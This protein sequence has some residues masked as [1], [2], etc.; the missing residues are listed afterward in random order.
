MPKIVRISD[1]K[2]LVPTREFRHARFFFESFNPIQS[3]VYKVYD[4][5]SNLCVAAST[6]A[7][8]TGVAEMLLSHEIRVRGGKGMYVA[9][10]KA[11][12][13]EKIDDWTDPKHHFSD[14]KISICTGDYYLTAARQR[15]LSRADLILITS[16]MLSS[17]CRNRTSEKSDFLQRVGCAVYDESHLLTVP[18]RGDH[19]EVALMNMTEI[20][21]GARLCFLSATMPNVDEVSGWLSR[22]NGMDT[23]LMVSDYRPTKLNVHYERYSDDSRNYD[24]TEAQKVAAAMAIVD[25]FKEDKF[26]VFAHTKRTGELMKIALHR[27]GE[28]ADFYNA[29]L[30]K[31][32]RIRLSSEFNTPVSSGGKRVIVAT[33]GLAWG[34]NL[35]ARRVIVLGV[36]R[37]MS[38]VAGY[39]IQQMVGR[40]GRPKYDP[41]GDAYVLLPGSRFDQHKGRLQA[42][43]RIESQL[44]TFVGG[45][46]PDGKRQDETR[47]NYKALAFHV[48]SEIHHNAIKTTKDV[49]RWYERSLAHHQNQWFDS[50]IVDNVLRLLANCG[51]IRE[52]GGEYKV[53]SS[54]AIASM[55]YYS[56]FDVADYRKSFGRVFGEGQ[57]GDDVAVAVA[58]GNTDTHRG[59]IVSRAEREEMSRF[60]AR[61]QE[62]NGQNEIPGPAV[63]AA[64]CYWNL[65]NGRANPAFNA[66]MRGLQFDFPRVCQV[67]QAVDE[68]ASKWDRFDWFR[69]L[70]L[71]VQYGV[72][73]DLVELCQLPHVGAVRA[74]RL[75]SGNIKTLSQVA[76]NPAKV[77][78]I[79]KLCQDKVD[80][81]VAE[82]RRIKI[83]E[84]CEQ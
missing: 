48:V 58:L 73:G 63:K 54:G 80:E 70:K 76:A 66:M 13:Q 75:V 52:E 23:H 38:E 8:K 46:S 16:E 56:P 39:D 29:D 21:R 78:N 18:G 43:E 51:A 74:Q 44:L 26:L 33:S 25:Y 41:A 72:K 36:H 7:G 14:L 71:R 40:S 64:F 24:D 49:H 68:M 69:Q 79:T 67:L 6:A 31:E 9:P 27:R 59:G 19:M 15:E 55:F 17:R 81:I 62:L 60:S 11:L 1:T 22:L 12:A 77:Q 4:Q 65:I 2:D 83:A 10:L 3:G 57:Q 32:T 53:T 20:N 45:R 30:D 35:A 50:D 82:A 28:P 61:V 84:E 34:T 5:P 42:P 47:R 37:G